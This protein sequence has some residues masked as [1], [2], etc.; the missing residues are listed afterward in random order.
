MDD[1]VMQELK[2]RLTESDRLDVS[3]YQF[4]N[5]ERLKTA[6]GAGWPDM[7]NR[8]FVATRSMIERRVADDDL[9]IPCATGFLVIFKALSGKLAEQ[10]TKRIAEDMER[11]F[12]GDAELAALNI[13]AFSEQL[14]IAEF[15]A[16]LAAADIEFI[17]DGDAPDGA[18]ALDGAPL[19]SG[20]DFYP[21]W[22]AN[23]EAA[24]SYFAAPRPT[25][26]QPGRGPAIP[27][28]RPE[29][30]DPRLDFDLDILDRAAMALERLID[31]GSRCAV[32][33]PAGFASLSLPRTR[34]SYVT[35][36]ARLPEALKPLVWVRLEDAPPSAPASVM[37]EKVRILR[38]LAAHLFVNTA[39]VALSVDS[40]TETGAGW[41]GGTLDPMRS[42]VQR[43]DLDRF[44]ALAGRRSVSTFVD[45][46]HSTAQLK[47]AAEAGIR[48][49]AGRAV[50]VYDAPRAPFR[51]LKAALLSKA[52]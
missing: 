42:S 2:R 34:A 38:G 44:T 20:L 48:L 13:E 49:I 15:E 29:K 26:N 43:N 10:T 8:V 31:S 21:V 17:D 37:A 40:Q 41:I 27:V 45:G 25:E 18:P 4:I 14:S 52:A 23:K 9:I 50:G 39:L 11:F 33:V 24:A 3:R 36:L 35:A 12:L 46:A 51:L 32:I 16:A 19:I 47:L 1:A 28:F 5:M 22:D 7:R 6:A 30:P